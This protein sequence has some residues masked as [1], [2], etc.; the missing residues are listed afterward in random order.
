M[1]CPH[2]GAQQLN[3]EINC[4]RCGQ[5]LRPNNVPRRSTSSTLQIPADHQPISMLGY[6]GFSFLFGIPVVGVI[7]MLVFGFG[8]AWSISVRNF[9]RAFLIYEVLVTAVGLLLFTL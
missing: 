7:C 1:N 9:A 2:C 6:L 5:A 3:D 4:E 8:S